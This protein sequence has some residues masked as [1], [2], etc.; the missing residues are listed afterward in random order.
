MNQPSDNLRQPKNY[1]QYIAPI[2]ILLLAIGA[3]IYGVLQTSAEP[4]ESSNHDSSQTERPAKSATAESLNEVERDFPDADSSSQEALAVAHD[5][6][7]TYV[8][9]EH[10][11][12][13]LL[14]ATEYGHE[15]DESA[16]DFALEH[17]NANWE[18]EAYY[19]A[20]LVMQEY[21]GLQQAELQKHMQHEP[22]GPKFSAEQTD[23]ALSKLD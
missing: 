10:S 21:P 2:I 18:D 13:L 19:Y 8:H 5:E 16:A 7:E 22:E 20:E 3:A 12:R 1:R 17:L 6:L 4:D 23:F 14:T 11:L 9:S 15:F